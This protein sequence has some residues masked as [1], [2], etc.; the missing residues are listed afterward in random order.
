MFKKQR[1]L[2]K[3]IHHVLVS[4]LIRSHPIESCEMFVICHGKVLGYYV[5]HQCFEINP[6]Q[7]HIK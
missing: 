3:L 7:V 5:V 4:I 6:F 1:Y 2:T